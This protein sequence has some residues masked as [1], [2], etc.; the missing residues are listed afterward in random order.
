MLNPSAITCRFTSSVTGICLAMRKSI[1]KKPGWLKALRPRFPVQPVGGTGTV[2]LGGITDP[3]LPK[4]FVGMMNSALWMKGEDVAAG[5]P[6]GTA[7]PAGSADG[8]PVEEPKSRFES[9]PSRTL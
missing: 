4:Q 6:A 9:N 3:S 1:S 2:A 7:A 5:K 8:R